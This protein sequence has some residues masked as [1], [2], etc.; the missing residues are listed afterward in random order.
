M[1]T[2]IFQSFAPNPYQNYDSSYREIPFQS[3]VCSAYAW[4]NP[5]TVLHDGMP[6]LLL[7]SI[8]T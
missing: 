8:T 4:C 1:I 7:A 5:R 3:S 2:S 6:V